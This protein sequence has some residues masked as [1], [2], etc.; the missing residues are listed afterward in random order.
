M[1]KKNDKYAVRDTMRRENW[2]EAAAA[3]EM[4]AMAHGRTRYDSHICIL[5][6]NHDNSLFGPVWSSWARKHIASP[7]TADC[8]C[9]RFIFILF[10][11]LF[12]PSLSLPRS[13]PFHFT[14]GRHKDSVFN[15]KFQHNFN[16]Y[17]LHL[18][19]R[20]FGDI[21]SVCFFV[22][23][24]GHEKKGKNNLIIC[25]AG[26]LKH[27]MVSDRNGRSCRV[28]LHCGTEISFVWRN[29]K[30]MRNIVPWPLP[31]LT[32]STHE[33]RMLDTIANAKKN[34]KNRQWN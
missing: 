27:R 31:P 23:S 22:D 7:R 9:F 25:Q 11:T 1:K 24:V 5:P 21:S 18:S 20:P 14:R 29:Y 10:P 15:F 6:V 32:P 26:V 2:I 13:R 28:K 19:F 30:V 16:V 4:T 8:V 12:L 3:V 34:R 33:N 17:T